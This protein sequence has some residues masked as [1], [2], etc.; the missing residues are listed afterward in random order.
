MSTTMAMRVSSSPSP[1]TAT[2][3]T[4]FSL[5]NTKVPSSISCTHSS[6]PSLSYT[7]NPLRS[8]IAH[9]RIKSFA[10]SKTTHRSAPFRVLCYTPAPFTPPNLQWIST[11]SSLSVH[12]LYFISS[13]YFF[14][15]NHLTFFINFSEN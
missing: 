4:T 9:D 10:K 12:F 7:F 11:I 13:F 3:P 8:F 5:L 1:V 14:N 6:L 15:F 2:A